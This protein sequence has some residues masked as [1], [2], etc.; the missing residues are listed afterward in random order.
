[1]GFVPLTSAIPVQRS[2]QQ[3]HLELVIRSARYKA[4]KDEEYMN[5]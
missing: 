4:V 3:A 1:M 2:N 5:I